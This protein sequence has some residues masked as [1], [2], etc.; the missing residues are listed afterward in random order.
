MGKLF[1][2]RWIASEEKTRIGEQG[3]F[4]R[5]VT[6]FRNWVRQD[7]SSEHPPEAGRYHLLVAD[8]CPWAHRTIITR[9][10]KGLNEAIGMTVAHFR[11]NDDGWWFPDGLDAFEPKDGKLPLHEFYSAAKGRYSGSATVPVLWDRKLQTIV[12]NESAEIIQMFNSE[13]P[14]QAT[15][16]IDLYPEED[17][18]EIDAVN[19]WV[20]K[21]INNGVYKCGFARTQEAYES[22]FIELFEGLEK[23]EE[24]LGLHRYLVGNNVTLADVRLFTTL[25]RFDAVYFGHF[26]CNLMRIIDYPNMSGYLRD[27]YQKP[28]FGETVKIELYKEGY[29]GRSPGINPRGLIPL[30]PKQDFNAPHQRAR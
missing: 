2:G 10:L 30:G 25:I 15:Q 24:R 6:T 21:K 16:S 19:D 20:Y 18:A 26:K 22:A 1:N 13:F 27:L 28:G 8:N 4:V 17:R 12:S 29:Y 14:N 9:N 7:G 3:Q 5:G 23:V 11:R